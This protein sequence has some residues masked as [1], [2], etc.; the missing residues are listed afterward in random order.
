MMMMMMIHDDDDDDC[1]GSEVAMMADDVND[2][3]A[4]V[5]S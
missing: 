4:W 1:D 5:P 3:R 2:I